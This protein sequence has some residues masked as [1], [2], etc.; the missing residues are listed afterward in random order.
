[1]K[2]INYPATPKEVYDSAKA[3]EERLKIRRNLAE[4]LDLSLED[5]KYIEDRIKKI[6]EYLD[7]Y[8]KNF[9]TK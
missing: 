6:K 9:D 2:N 8:S 5:V 3:V 4:D 1:M 7:W